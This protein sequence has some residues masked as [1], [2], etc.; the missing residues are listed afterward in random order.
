MPRTTSKNATHVSAAN[1]PLAGREL[2]APGMPEILPA[3]AWIK[4]RER[5]QRL[6]TF[7][8]SLGHE[9]LPTDA[10]SRRL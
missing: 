5:F 8:S 10:A 9:P 3:E 2:R 7:P 1:C 4:G 6:V